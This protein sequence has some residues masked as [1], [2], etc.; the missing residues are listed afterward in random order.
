MEGPTERLR[1]FCRQQMSILVVFSLL[2]RMYE[3][4]D[5]FLQ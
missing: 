5:E 1:S 2:H 4:L 3:L